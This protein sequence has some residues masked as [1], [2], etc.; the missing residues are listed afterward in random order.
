MQKTTPPK[1]PHNPI[2]KW[3]IEVKKKNQFSEEVQ[4]VN[5]YMKNSH[6]CSHQ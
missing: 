1:I 4:M 2:D 6:I 5:K 3:A